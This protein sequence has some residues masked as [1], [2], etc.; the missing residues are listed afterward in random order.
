M[1][2]WHSLTIK[3]IFFRLRVTSHGLSHEEVKTRLLSDGANVLPSDHRFSAIRIFGR[4]FFS[5]LIVI[6]LLAAV[7]TLILKE[8]VDMVVIIAA[9]L[10]NVVLVFFQEYKAEKTL[11]NLKRWLVHSTKVWRENALH[12]VEAQEL[13]VGDIIWLSA[14]DKVPADARIIEAVQC[15]VNESVLTGEAFPEDKSSEVLEQNVVLGDRTNMLFGGTVLESGSVKAVVVATGRRS[16]LGRIAVLV[17][18]AKKDLTPLQKS[19]SGFSGNI[20]MILVMLSVSIF[21]LGLAFQRGWYEMLF[22]TIAMIVAAIPE[23]LPAAITIVLALGAQRIL[24]HRGLIRKLVSAETLGSA[25]VICTDKTGTLTL[26]SMEVTGIRA[27]ENESKFLFGA[28]QWEMNADD[29]SQ[30]EI[31]KMGMMCNDAFVENPED[32]A[33]GWK[34]RGN[35]TEK[36]LIL[37]G[38][39]AGISYEFLNKE[40]VRIAE[41]PFTSERKFMAVLVKKGRE[42]FVIVKGAPEIIL[43]R[44]S[45]IQKKGVERLSDVEKKTIQ[46]EYEGFTKKGLRVLAFG[47]KKIASGETFDESTLHDLI[48][49]GFAALKDPLRKEAYETVHACRKAGLTVVLVTGDHLMT[50]KA[51][52]EELGVKVTARQVMSGKDIE[53]LSD[54]ELLCKISTIRIFARV[55]PKHKLR[56]VEAWQK[57]GKVVAMTGDGVNDAPALK[58]ADIGVALGSGSDAAKNISDIVLLDDNLKTLLEAIEEGRI[59]Y[60]NIQKVITFNLAGTFSEMLVIGGSVIAGLPLPVLPAQVLWINIVEDAF[61]SLSLAFEAGEHEVMYDRPRR[62]KAPLLTK[63]MKIIIF[64]IGIC[65]DIL[66]FA[67]YFFMQRSGLYDLPTMQTVI[68][69]GLGLNALLYVFSLKSFRKNLW[70]TDLWN[71]ASTIYASLL[72]MALLFSAVYLPVFQN[73]LH[74]VPLPSY[75]WAVPIGIGVFQVLL[76]EVVKYFFIVKN[77][78]PQPELLKI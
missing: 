10:M 26:A 33:N 49:L 77:H 34:I 51:I 30:Y 46:K 25:S 71:N 19:L 37:A 75:H 3:E 47:M 28:R 69:V 61:P 78:Y 68:F 20:A 16:E 4:Q 17:K 54:T 27:Y 7:L 73:F 29:A 44:C 39:H 32:E 12:V 9:V 62:P 35:A 53:A 21:I 18:K 13:V 65:S 31:L 72:G 63:E 64:F 48:F 14:G 1:N 74:T 11:Q 52:F 59:M 60:E 76:I 2:H 22:I 55:S 36:A 56:I 15:S 58:K 45:L 70:N 67:W 43:S 8:W 50:A 66:L 23:G 57:K 5:P 6:L 38:A 40:Y 41:I 24:T 42:R